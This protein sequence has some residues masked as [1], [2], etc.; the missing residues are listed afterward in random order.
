MLSLPNMKKLLIISLFISFINNSYGQQRIRNEEERFAKFPALDK[1][2]GKWEYR[3]GEKYFMIELKKEQYITPSGKG[4]MDVIRGNHSY[5]ERNI[6]LDASKENERT[7]TNGIYDYENNNENVLIFR[8]RE[9]KKTNVYA[10]GKLTFSP[11]SPNT[12]LWS[13][14]K[15]INIQYPR[16]IVKFMVPLNVKLTKVREK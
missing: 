10:D 15:P 8:F 16:E 2:L 11:S 12:L 3:E 14:S 5:S 6:V 9:S 7:I 1:F 4:G 13:L